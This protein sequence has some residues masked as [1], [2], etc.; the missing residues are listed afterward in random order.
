MFF[1]GGRGRGG[2]GEKHLKRE[3]VSLNFASNQNVFLF[4]FSC[5]YLHQQ[6]SNGRHAF[7]KHWL[8]WNMPG[9]RFSKSNFK[10]ES[11][12]SAISSSKNWSTGWKPNNKKP[13][14]CRQ[15]VVR[16][17]CDKH[18]GCKEGQDELGGT[19]RRLVLL[20]FQG[21]IRKRA[22]FVS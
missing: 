5:T 17:C 18:Y 7:R 1:W 21:N 9:R 11:P 8:H 20:V 22:N 4:W 16:V 6:T 3:A 12:A 15:W 13:E 19:E 2:G 10:L 14:C